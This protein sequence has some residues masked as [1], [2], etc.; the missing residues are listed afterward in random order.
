M[1][2][3]CLLN[4]LECSS[5]KFDDLVALNSKLDKSPGIMELLQNESQT[6]A[7]TTGFI[8]FSRGKAKFFDRESQD[9]SDRGV[10]VWGC[11]GK[12]DLDLI[13]KHMTSGKLVIEFDI[14][15]W[16]AETYTLVPGKCKKAKISYE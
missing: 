3:Y 7:I 12:G 4:V 14:E 5:V 8:Q 2:Q 11:I 1:S 15:G 13:A 6:Q 16:T 9:Y 10:N